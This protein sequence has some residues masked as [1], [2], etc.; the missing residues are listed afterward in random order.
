MTR[1]GVAPE[2]EPALA[3]LGAAT[4]ARAVAVVLPGGRADSFDPATS[5]QLAGL[6]MR[7]I[8][9]ALH[10]DGARQGLD[11][12]SLRYRYRGWNGDEM[13]PVADARWALQRIH[14]RHGSLPVVLVGHSMG[15]RVAMRVA[16]DA[17]V[18]A[19]V[20]LAP[21]LL[22]G[23]PADQLAGRR[24]LIAHGDHDTVTS[25]DASRRFARRAEGAGAH[26]SYLLVQG[27]RHAML[28]RWR[29]WHALAAAYTLDVLGL[30][31]MPDRVTSALDRG[32]A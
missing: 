2:R 29:L 4:P 23:D 22:D 16:G 27:E 20:G 9:A 3:K 25:A 12:W 1:P 18:V 10:R 8:A 15:G 11:V 24:V 6:R 31:P 17:A 19:A 30:A 32:I 7:P 13:S 26:V 14:A 5:R 28:R 21:W